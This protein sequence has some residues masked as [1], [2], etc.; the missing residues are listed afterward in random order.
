[1]D[2][3]RRLETRR[4]SARAAAR[5][6]PVC[7]VGQVALEVARRVRGVR[8]SRSRPTGGTG[9][10]A[11]ERQLVSASPATL[12]RAPAPRRPTTGPGGCVAPGTG[13]GR[14]HTAQCKRPVSAALSVVKSEVTRAL[15]SVHWAISKPSN[16]ATFGAHLAHITEMSDGL[17]LSDLCIAD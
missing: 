11:G 10:A 17:S 15:L 6:R 2:W 12:L 4:G 14:Q 7:L 3:G 1:M 5:W 13:D 16:D 9:S 8:G